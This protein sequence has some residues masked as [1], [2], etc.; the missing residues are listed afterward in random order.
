MKLLWQQFA[1]RFYSSESAVARKWIYAKTFKGEP[2]HANFRLETEPLPTALRQGEF[3][4]QAEYLSVDPY[5]RPYMLAY[6]E[7]SL[8]IG[9][10]IA[11]VTQSAN[12][13]FPVGANIFGQ[14]GWRT[15]TVCDPDALEKDK[16]YVL[17]DFGP[18]PRSLGLGILG[19]PGNTAYFG[20]RELCQP[21]AGETIVVS[22]A[23]G[24][25]GSVVGQIGK[26]LGCRVIG[27]AGSDAKC[28]WLE[29]DLGF[30]GTINYKRNNVYAELKTVAPKGVDC[31]FDNVGGDITETV[32]KQ[33]NV[34]GRIA[35]C[36]AISNY[37]SAVGKVADPQ[38]QFV[39]KQLRMEGF[40]VW[41]WND[42]WMEGIEAN[43]QSIRE[44]RLAYEET[45]TEGF[46]KMPDA[47]IDMLRGG[48]TGK[49]VV[50]V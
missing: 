19:M 31:Y 27:I 21:R 6:P 39:F 38:R 12:E 9:G 50:K 42:R 41:R 4:A 22:G 11:R 43:L 18:L 13:Q 48:N 25:V 35:V 8:M 46:D 44:G 3:L 15:H 2:S 23:A 10:Q 14:F 16:P 47:F 26:N 17:P 1:R 40:L 24:A 7:G 36:G 30:D 29:K 28:Q 20:L 45:I 32:L 34:Y 5:M 33:M 37:N 49:A